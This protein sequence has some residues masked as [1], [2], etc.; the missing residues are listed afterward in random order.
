LTASHSFLVN[1]N[2]SQFGY[3]HTQSPTNPYENVV[4]TTNVSQLTLDWSSP[5]GGSGVSPPAVVNNVVYFGSDNHYLYALDAKT[6]AKLW[7]SLTGSPIISSP[8]VANGV[9]YTG[10]EDHHLYAFHL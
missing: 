1:T 10:S 7:S 9:V 3:N 8:A 4:S 2:W 6:G 5:T